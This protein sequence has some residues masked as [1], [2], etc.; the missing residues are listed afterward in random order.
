MYFGLYVS[1]YFISHNDF[2][3]ENDL[4]ILTDI[5]L[6]NLNTLHRFKHLWNMS[7]DLYILFCIWPNGKIFL[8]TYTTQHMLEYLWNIYISHDFTLFCMIAKWMSFS[9][10]G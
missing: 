1:F 6:C 7:H 4:Y 5:L 3:I 10:Q 8:T 2:Y 9:Y